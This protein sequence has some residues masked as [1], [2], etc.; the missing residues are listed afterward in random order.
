MKL[1]YKVLLL[2][3]SLA[4]INWPL[5]PMFMNYHACAYYDH[6]IFCCCGLSLIVP[7][8]SA[9]TKYFSKLKK[10]DLS[11]ERVGLAFFAM[12]SGF[13]LLVVNGINTSRMLTL[14]FDSPICMENYFGKYISILA[15]L[16]TMVTGTITIILLQR[17]L[18]FI[19]R[20][21]LSKSAV[22]LVW[23]IVTGAF[24]AFGAF[25]YSYLKKGCSVVETY[26]IVLFANV[27][28]F[29]AMT[30]LV[31]VIYLKK[32]IKMKHLWLTRIIAVIYLVLYVPFNLYWL[33]KG[34]MMLWSPAR[35]E[36][37]PQHILFSAIM[38]AYGLTTT[39]LLFGFIAAPFMY[40]YWWTFPKQPS[41][42]S[43]NPSIDPQFHGCDETPYRKLS[44][45]SR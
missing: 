35:T 25:I 37:L 14:W 8:G 39:P 31:T 12:L 26:F 1:V 42:P 20:F 19:D 24:G 28:F 44:T 23:I 2:L 6:V 7:F 22:C 33:V 13:L 38:I 34:V 36:C 45:G 18:E 43:M 11:E 21:N 15:C 10:K 5:I 41:A 17:W 3:A 4:G 29:Q 40:I 30:F 27:T 9:I 32:G 16:L